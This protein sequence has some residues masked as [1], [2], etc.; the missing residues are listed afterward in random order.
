MNEDTKLIHICEVCG[1]NKIMTPKEAL[2]EGWDYPPGIGVFGLISPRTCSKHPITDT[3]YWR[4]INHKGE[5]PFVPTE[6]DRVLVTR[7]QGE[8]A[9]IDPSRLN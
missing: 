2:D 4:L 9:T 1:E 5:E 6:E 7:I 8:P 3:L